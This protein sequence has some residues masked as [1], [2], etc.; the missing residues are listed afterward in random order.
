[1]KIYA[2][3][4]AT[5]KL[6]INAFEAMQEILLNEYGNPSQPYSFGR[7]AAKILKEAKCIIAECIN[8]DP[9]EVY[10]TSGGTESDNWAIKG[11]AG[12]IGR[13]KA[14]LCSK[15]EHHAVL[16]TCESLETQGFP[17]AYIPCDDKGIVGPENVLKFI[18]RPSIL[19]VMMAN[20]E[21]G[22]IQ[23]IKELAS[24]AHD[25]GALFHT[26]AVQAVGHIPIDVKEVDVDLLSASAHKFNGPRGVGFL[27]VKRGT[28]ILP[29]IDGGSQQNGMRGGTENTAGIMAMAIA[30][31]NN[32]NEIH[33]NIIHLRNLETT[34]I[35]CLQNT[36]I[37]FILNGSDHKLP[38]I[39]SLSLKGMNGEMLLH[40]LDLMGICI[41]TGSACDGKNNKVSHVIEAIGVPTEYKTG[42]IRLSFGKNNTIKDIKAICDAIKKI[43]STCI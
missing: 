3:N 35:N 7:R 25:H 32:C 36:K 5:T 27:Y 37:D 41:S 31:R 26:D 4:A 42:T 17:V 34:L 28:S 18:D 1:M 13:S 22:T 6:D 43:H 33:H 24:I 8:A 10:F 11:S 23:P 38:G 19:T 12:F 15:I 29:L 16:R 14:I 9:D 39:I 40:R 21:I 30:L 20:N 2:D